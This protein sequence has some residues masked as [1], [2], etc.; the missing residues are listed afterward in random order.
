M[1]CGEQINR[2]HVPLNM[3]PNQNSSSVRSNSLLF[4]GLRAAGLAAG[5]NTVLYLAASAGGF[6]NPDSPTGEPVL[7]VGLGSVILL[8]A[9]AAAV[10]TAVFA[11]VDRHVKHPAAVMGVVGATVLLVASLIPYAMAPGGLAS[12]SPTNCGVVA[13]LELMHGFTA[14][15]TLGVLS[16]WKQRQRTQAALASTSQPAQV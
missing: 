10:G 6:L 16:A 9:V 13:V 14:I 3:T 7:T 4:A 2:Q 1:P 11:V 12:I 8:S 5:V 15:M